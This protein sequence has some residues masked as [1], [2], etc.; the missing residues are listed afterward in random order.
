MSE[1]NPF[2]GCSKVVMD[3][4]VLEYLLFNPL[5]EHDETLFLIQ[6]GYFKP[7]SYEKH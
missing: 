3:G 6:R 2:E 5:T 7:T 4:P 1:N